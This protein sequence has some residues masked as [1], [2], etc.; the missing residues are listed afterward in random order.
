MKEQILRFLQASPAL[1]YC[2][3]CISRLLQFPLTEVQSILP[4]FIVM[5][6]NIQSTLDRCVECEALRTVFRYMPPTGV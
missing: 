6:P 2:R 4:R 3:I 1:F 5:H